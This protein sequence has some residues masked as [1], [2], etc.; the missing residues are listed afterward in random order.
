MAILMGI[1][2]A[3]ILKTTNMVI[4]FA[5]L[6]HAYTSVLGRNYWGVIG[7]ILMFLQRFSESLPMDEN[8]DRQLTS[9][10]CAIN[11]IVFTN[12]I[13]ELKRY[14]EEGGGAFE[15]KVV[16]DISLNATKT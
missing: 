16:V 13:L 6:S 2:K 12:S 15:R 3:T 5:I 1:D 11:S 14:H 8:T 7:A 9:L 10:F 4:L